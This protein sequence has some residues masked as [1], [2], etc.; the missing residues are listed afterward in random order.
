MKKGQSW[1]TVECECPYCGNI[2]EVLSSDNIEAC[3]DCNE[4][5][6]I[7]EPSL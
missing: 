6:E 7:D 5:F 1:Y 3:E 4:E 2:Q